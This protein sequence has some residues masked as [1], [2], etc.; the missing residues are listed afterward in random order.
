MDEKKS[1]IQEHKKHR[2]AKSSYEQC[3]HYHFIICTKDHQAHKI[4]KP[5]S[6]IKLNIEGEPYAELTALGKICEK[7]FRNIE[8][9]Y[10]FVKIEALCIM[11]N[12]IHLLFLMESETGPFRTDALQVISSTK[13]VITK[14]IGESIWQKSSYDFITW[15][16]KIFRIV[17]QYVVDNPAKWYY[18]KH[19]NEIKFF[20]DLVEQEK[21]GS[22]RSS[23]VQKTG[24]E[25]AVPVPG[26]DRSVADQKQPT[27]SD[28]AVADQKQDVR[29]TNGLNDQGS[30]T[31]G[32][33][34]GGSLP[35]H[36]Q[37]FR[38]KINIDIE[39]TEPESGEC[40][41]DQGS[42]TTG[43]TEGGSL[44]IKCGGNE[45]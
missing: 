24:S 33:T 38:R 15:K 22:E 28:R 9:V 43:T 12:H 27:G 3:A 21:A 45:K 11:P 36:A 10:P 41:N 34:E 44:P 13:G 37:P 18:K 1:N 35:A 8:K 14:E 6:I 42:F 25:R 26:S 32:T 17:Q 7:H 19:D 5:L 30:F 4:T 2:L 20:S 16:A 29:R 31:T 39:Y 40:G 23:T